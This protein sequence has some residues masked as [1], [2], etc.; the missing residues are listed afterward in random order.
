LAELNEAIRGL[1]NRLNERPFRKLPGSRRSV[2]EIL[3]RL[4]L[5]PLPAQRYTYAEWKKGRVQ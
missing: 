4:A 1:F 3:E 5:R 2:F